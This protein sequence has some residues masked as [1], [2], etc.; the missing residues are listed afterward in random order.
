[1]PSHSDPYVAADPGLS[2]VD[3]FEELQS[4]KA[5]VEIIISVESRQRASVLSNEF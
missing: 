4:E 3:E 1:M 2:T 5:L